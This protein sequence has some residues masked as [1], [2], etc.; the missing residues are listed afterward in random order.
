V[1]SVGALSQVRKTIQASIFRTLS[2]D[3]GFTASA[4]ATDAVFEELARFGIE[5]P[6]LQRLT[7]L[8]PIEELRAKPLPPSGD[9]ENPAAN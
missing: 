1:K 2:F 7:E 6:R 9:E 8:D 4:V 3:I 5:A